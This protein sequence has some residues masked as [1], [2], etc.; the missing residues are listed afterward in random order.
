MAEP[1]EAFPIAGDLLETVLDEP[2]VLPDELTGTQR[3]APAAIADLG[4]EAWSWLDLW[5]ILRYWGVPDDRDRL[6]A[7]LA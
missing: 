6:A 7:Y 1:V 2:G 3:E 5:E 4:E